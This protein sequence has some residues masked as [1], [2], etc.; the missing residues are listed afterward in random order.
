[1]EYRKFRSEDGLAR[2][3]TSTSQKGEKNRGYFYETVEILAS[4]KDCD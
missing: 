2:F 3:E 4:R 1:M